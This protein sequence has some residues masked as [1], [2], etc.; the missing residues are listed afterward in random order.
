M[1]REVRRMSLDGPQGVSAEPAGTVGRWRQSKIERRDALIDDMLS[2][3]RSYG[4]DPGLGGIVDELGISKSLLSRNFTDNADLAAATVSRYYAV[5]LEPRIR[6][7]LSAEPT[8]CMLIRAVAEAYVD[9][10]S[11]D[12]TAYSYVIAHSN[13]SGRGLIADA[14][15]RMAQM[16]TA[17]LV[18]CFGGRISAT[19][20]AAPMAFV[21]LGTVRLCVHWWTN[22]D[23]VTADELVDCVTSLL[24]GGI[25]GIGTF[26]NT[27]G[28]QSVPSE[29]G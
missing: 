2:V 8:E 26:P 27:V 16:L 18:T 29:N 5:E 22:Q 7:A 4:R 10:V 1:K 20:G 28:S 13:P 3:V 23:V 12:A 24:W 17:T 9:V 14:D 11:H 25:R 19:E 21:I 15:Y 6:S